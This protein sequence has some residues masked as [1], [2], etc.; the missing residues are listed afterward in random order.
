[1][2]SDEQGKALEEG[3]AA[4][5]FGAAWREFETRSEGNIL[6]EVWDLAG[7]VARQEA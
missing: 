2:S 5:V 1:M 4:Q 7:S 3:E 6:V